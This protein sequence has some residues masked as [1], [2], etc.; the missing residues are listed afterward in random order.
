MNLPFN[1]D[2]CLRLLPKLTEI[3]SQLNTQTKRFDECNQKIKDLEESIDD[4]IEKQVEKAIE[5]FR[6]REE[7]KCNVIIH[8]VPESATENRKEEDSAKLKEIFAVMKCEDVKAKSFVR[9]GRPIDGQQR[10]IKVVLGSVTNKHQLLGGTKL[11]RTKDGDG[12][13]T[14]G[15][16]NVFVT[17]DLTKEEREKN[18]LLR[19]ELAKRKNDEKN[20]NLVIY[21]GK[22]TDKKDITD[23][24]VGKD[25]GSGNGACSQPVQPV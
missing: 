9:L 7:R 24:G 20:E 21:R 6:D 15:W 18:R 4:K 14:H 11:L 3:V 22:I 12:S 8:N 17:P 5:A 1:C 25:K 2:G 16:S 23:H 19:Q 10:L 13:S